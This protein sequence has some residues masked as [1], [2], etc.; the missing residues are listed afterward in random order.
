MTD[1]T[2]LLRE[3][4]LLAAQGH[5]AKALARAQ[6]VVQTVPDH[7]EAFALFMDLRA[8]QI[9]LQQAEQAKQAADQA[10]QAATC[11]G[12][13]LVRDILRDPALQD[14][15]RLERHGYQTASQNEEDGMLAEI[16]RRIGTAN[17]RFFEF[18][19][20][21]G[22]QNNTLHFLFQGWGGAW[23]EINQPKLTFIRQTFAEP[24]REG[25]LQVLGVPV[26]AENIDGIVG[27]IG[28][29]E[30][31]DLLSIDIDGNDWHVWKALMAIRPRVVVVEY[32]AR[33]PPPIRIV[34]AY[35]AA[36]AWSAATHLGASLQSFVDLGAEKGYRLV[37]CS[38]SGINAIFV[39][40]DLT[41]DLFAEPATAEAL[42]HPP[43]IQLYA[44]KAFGTIEPSH[45]PPHANG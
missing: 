19:V 38:I 15:R 34:Q 6:A 16:F 30:D 36:Y 18:G 32:N 43:R 29:P 1:I 13:F 39:R 37:G 28:L 31:L 21:N 22:L 12:Q 24:I 42:F 5:F 35:D 33:F 9:A 14:P 7:A 45:F 44:V 41:A 2:A 20:G 25:R 17:R 26:T 23:I 40:S 27:S 4:R 3:I 8:D 10:R 11:Q